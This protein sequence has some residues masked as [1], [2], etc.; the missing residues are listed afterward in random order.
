MRTTKYSW[1]C[2]AREADYSGYDP[3]SGG[4]GGPGPGDKPL[5][6]RQEIW[7]KAFFR[8]DKI[9]TEYTAKTDGTFIYNGVDTFGLLYFRTIPKWPADFVPL[10]NSKGKVFQPDI[11]PTAYVWWEVV[12]P[13]ANGSN[14]VGSTNNWIPLIGVSN[15]AIGTRFNKHYEGKLSSFNKNIL[16]LDNK[17]APITTPPSVESFE[18]AEQRLHTVIQIGDSIVNPKE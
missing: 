3:V 11:K 9:G 10:A 14:V 1:I 6:L 7:I 16:P 12:N 8:D 18:Q 5:H 13:T 4:V 15:T 2:L 17:G